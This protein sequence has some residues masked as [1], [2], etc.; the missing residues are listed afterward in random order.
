MPLL[1]GSSGRFSFLLKIGGA[2]LL[3]ALAD[4]LLLSSTAVAGTGCFAL[5]LTILL[6]LVTPAI[7][8]SRGAIVALASA[9]ALALVLVEDPSRLAWFLFWIAIS[10]AALMP[11]VARFD[12]ASLWAVRLFL[13]AVTGPFAWIADARRVAHSRRRARG[14]GL[15]RLLPLVALPVVGGIVFLSLFAAANP[16]I[17]DALAAIRLPRLDD[18]FAFHAL[19]WIVAFAAAWP[20]LRP[21][22]LVTSLPRP[23]APSGTAPIPGVT[24][25]SVRLSLVAFNL[26]FAL[27]N[28]LD[29][30]FLW[31]GAGLPEGMTLAA[32]AHRGAYPLI[33]TALL[34]GLFVLVTLRP[35]TDTAADPLIRR[36]VVAWVAQNIL[37]VASSMLRT[38]EYIDAYSLTRLRIAA[39]AWMVL[40]AIGLGLICWRLMRGKSGAWLINANAITATVM[41]C[42]AS[43][44]DLGAVAASW[45]VRHAREAGGR[46]EALDLCY[47]SGLGGSALLPLIE[48]E[49]RTSNPAFRDR[50]RSVRSV[51]LVGLRH[52]QSGP[53]WS[54]RG[55]RRLSAAMAIL[56]PTPAQ[57]PAAPYGR[58]C[59]GAPFPPSPPLVEAPV[60][61]APQPVEN[62]SVAAPVLTGEAQR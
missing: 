8:R 22:R 48:L 21:R 45:N 59:D 30:I 18:D 32:Y 11:R 10:V 16:L 56:G 12:T 62:G 38:I 9:L 4:F 44:V 57:A 17:G 60:P 15:A 53:S 52:R 14:P 5:A 39:L 43:I 3:A 54:W 33:A 36:L 37:L 42:T 51:V 20:T 6:S 46:G 55:A 25:A 24:T 47:L 28:L 31:S 19:V 23:M 58:Q 40:V 26:I 2:L 13:H 29:L 27:Q 34:A 35:G 7:G 41:L 61:P 50:V 49:R 1:S